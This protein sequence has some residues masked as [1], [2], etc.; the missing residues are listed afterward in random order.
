MKQ[1]RRRR[2]S[3]ALG[4]GVDGRRV[5]FEIAVGL[6]EE[7]GTLLGVVHPDLREG[8]REGGREG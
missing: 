4:R 8:G 2:A 7:G 6:R 3:I 5:Q 1:H